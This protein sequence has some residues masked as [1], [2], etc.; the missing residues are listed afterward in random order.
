MKYWLFKLIVIALAIGAIA[1]TD[2]APSSLN[3]PT[4]MGSLPNLTASI[5]D[6]ETRT[7]IDN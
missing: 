4:E 6:G 7:Y 2:D 1:C 5:E 3:T